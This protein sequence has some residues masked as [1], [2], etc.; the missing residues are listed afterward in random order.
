MSARGEQHE[1]VVDDIG[2]LLVDANVALLPGRTRDLLGRPTLD[3][4][5]DLPDRPH[6]AGLGLVVGAV[7]EHR[8][9][10]QARLARGG[11]LHHLHRGKFSLG[12]RIGGSL[13]LRQAGELVRPETR[14]AHEVE[15][16]HWFDRRPGAPPVIQHEVPIDLAEAGR[17]RALAIADIQ[18]LLVL[19][20]EPW[21][22][23]DD[24]GPHHAR[25]V[26]GRLPQFLGQQEGIGALLVSRIDVPLGDRIECQRQRE[27]D[28]RRQR[29][30]EPDPRFPADASH[31]GSDPHIHRVK[32]APFFRCWQLP[33][34][35]RRG[36][37]ALPRCPSHQTH[38]MRPG[39]R[40]RARQESRHTC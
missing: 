21:I 14:R 23:R 6:D 25:E 31:L 2:G 10:A 7:E 29:R 32:Y 15:E 35:S 20:L 1:Q 26:L 34:G 22:A 24:V 37:R 40:S 11:L 30:Q 27:S 36:R 33:E 38:R 4:K 12:Q 17:P 5:T 28:D 18:D 9:R 16:G 13:C 19:R 39:V 8:G 3:G